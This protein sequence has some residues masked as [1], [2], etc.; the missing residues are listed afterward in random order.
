MKISQN[1]EKS[2]FYNVYKTVYIC[3]YKQEYKIMTVH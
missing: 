1:N 3:I 2:Y